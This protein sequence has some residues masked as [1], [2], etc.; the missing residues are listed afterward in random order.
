MLKYLK[1]LLFLIPLSLTAIE[2]QQRSFDEGL[3]AYQ[4]GDFDKA[5]LHFEAAVSG[6]LKSSEAYNNLGLAYFKKG[7]IGLAVLNYERALRQN[8]YNTEARHNLKVAQQYIDTSVRPIQG[9][10]LFRA[11]DDLASSL[12]S[13]TWV[14][15]FWAFLFAAT[16]IWGYWLYY[17]NKNK[18]SWAF[19]LAICL[20]L[21][22]LLPILLARQAAYEEHHGSWCIIV[23]S[24][25]G[26]RTEPGIQGED[27]MVVG[28]GVK[29]RITE[30]S[31]EWH[32]IRLD[33]GVLGWI[34]EKMVEQ[35]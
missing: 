35:I 31:G 11:W 15:I 22:A 19:R 33:N 12:A 14:F 5:I 27:I 4:S 6:E 25:A 28:A 9:F 26:I 29:A 30:S 20:T 3:N 10:W 21:T 13:T 32:R 2:E 24:Q 18:Q 1:Y 8:S 23:A 16:A 17:S 34:P 7:E